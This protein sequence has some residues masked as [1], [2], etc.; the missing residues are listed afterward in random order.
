MD[1]KTHLKAGAIVGGA[2]SG[3]YLISKLANNEKLDWSDLGKAA[4]IT[5]GSTMAAILPDILEPA[6][7]PRHRQ[8]FHSVSM[9]ILIIYVMYKINESEMSESN[10]IALISFCSSYMSHLVLDST[11]PAGLPLVGKI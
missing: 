2:I 7:N 4:L 8:F 10:K 9:S 6:F 5:I 1:G 3:I 11:T